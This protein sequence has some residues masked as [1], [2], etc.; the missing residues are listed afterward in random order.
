MYLQYTSFGSSGKE[1]DEADDKYKGLTKENIF[2]KLST[3][4][5]KKKQ[6]CLDY[7]DDFCSEIIKTK[8]FIRAPKDVVLFVVKRDSINVTEVELFDAV[9]ACGQAELKA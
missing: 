3:A 1:E 6:I 5:G 8:T 2:K 4:K 7:L 9:I